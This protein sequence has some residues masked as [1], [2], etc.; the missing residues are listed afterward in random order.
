MK[1]LNS[2]KLCDLVDLTE[3]KE[4]KGHYDVNLIAN[5]HCN[6]IKYATE[7]SLHEYCLIFVLKE[8]NFNRTI[9]KLQTSDKQ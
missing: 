5:Q 9:E 3:L 7:S 4:E 2:V 6:K 8:A 1:Q